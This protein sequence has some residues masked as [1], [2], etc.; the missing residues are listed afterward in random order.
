MPPLWLLIVGAVGAL[1][2]LAAV[3]G[4]RW[5]S[6]KPRAARPTNNAPGG[7]RV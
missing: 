5:Q 7:P 3:F 2:V 1:N 6:V 4:A